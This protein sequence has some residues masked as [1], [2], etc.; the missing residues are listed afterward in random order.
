MQWGEPT[1]NLAHLTGVELPIQLLSRPDSLTRKQ[2]VSLAG[3]MESQKRS[4]VKSLSYR[5]FGTLVTMVVAWLVTGQLGN[6]MVVGLGDSAAKI[7]LFYFHERLWMR[8][9][10]GKLKP[11]DFQI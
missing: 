9:E 7:F 10:W 1:S 8:V 2:G 11:P 3:T 4:I 5:A 6:A